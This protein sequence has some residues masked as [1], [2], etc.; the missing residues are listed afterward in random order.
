[1]HILYLEGVCTVRLI[2][3]LVI[4]SMNFGEIFSR[5][6]CASYVHYNSARDGAIIILLL[7]ITSAVACP[8]SARWH[9]PY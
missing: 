2:C 4:S 7:P 8:V 1:M 9:L 3:I 5:A 6:I